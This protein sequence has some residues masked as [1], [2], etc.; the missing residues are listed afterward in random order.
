[1]ISPRK[2][3]RKTRT[4]T[5]GKTKRL[6][7]RRLAQQN[8]QHVHNLAD[9]LSD[10]LHR[11][12]VGVGRGQ[13]THSMGNQEP[14]LQDQELLSSL[15]ELLVPG[16]HRQKLDQGVIHLIIE[17]HHPNHEME[18]E[19]RLLRGTLVHHEPFLLDEKE[20]RLHTNRNHNIIDH[21]VVPRM[22][23]EN[24]Q[25]HHH[26]LVHLP[27]QTHLNVNHPLLPLRILN[28]DPKRRNRPRR[29]SHL[30]KTRSCKQRLFSGSRHNRKLVS[31]CR[32]LLKLSNPSYWPL[33]QNIGTRI[34]NCS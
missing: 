12:A 8:V 16:E 14:P 4:R 21:L 24:R 31:P 6:P 1:M 2:A 22:E 13:I 23:R 34:R 26:N 30:L 19:C 28:H 32:V 9:H 29:M 17:L 20:V 18:G 10:K 3:S 15:I 33:R 7:N 25:Q 11:Q 27:I 5:R